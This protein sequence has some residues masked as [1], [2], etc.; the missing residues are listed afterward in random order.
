MNQEEKILIIGSGALGTAFANILIDGGHDNVLI[1]GIDKQEL[2]DLSKGKN[3]KHFPNNKKLHKI[4]TSNNFKEAMK[5]VSFIV[6]AL[7]SLVMPKV[8]EDI[9]KHLNSKDV[10]VISGSKGFWPNSELPIHQGIQNN[11]ENNPNIKGVVSI[12]GPSYAEELI[13]KSLTNVCAVSKS[14]NIAKIAQELFTNEYFKIYVQT[15]VIGAEVGA[16]YKNILAIGAGI[17]H[18]KGFKINTIAAYITRGIKEMSVF[19]DYLGGS[20]ST[21]IG[22]TGLGDLLLTA[23]SDLSRNRSFGISFVKNKKLAMESNTTLEGLYALKIVEKIRKK[24]NIYLPIV[25]C[26][27][28][29]IYENQDIDKAIPIL[30]NRILKNE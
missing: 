20:F 26:L 16:I 12:F 19:N 17:L 11:L 7:P 6:L 10:V 8:I 18:V 1:Y 27:Y 14:E 28:Q 23:M 2:E 30:W 13:N 9:N 4:K 21:I 24:E 5:E 3:L 25:S 15:D 22:L 29:V